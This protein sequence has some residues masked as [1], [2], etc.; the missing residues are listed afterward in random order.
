VSKVD[1]DAMRRYEQTRDDLV[2]RLVVIEES[3]GENRRKSITRVR[4]RLERGK[5][6]LAVVGEF[7]SG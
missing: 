5:F 3:I 2:A 4:S 6:V 1:A 7:S